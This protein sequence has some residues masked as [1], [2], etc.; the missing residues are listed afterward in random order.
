V[1]YIGFA[2]ERGFGG[3]LVEGWNGGWDW[4]K[5]AVKIQNEP[6]TG[7]PSGSAERA[8]FKLKTPIGAGNHFWYCIRWACGVDMQENHFKSG[9]CI[10][11]RWKKALMSY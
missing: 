2:A 1:K 8:S 4:L 9:R 3:V 10:D 11:Q 6:C 7:K 5:I